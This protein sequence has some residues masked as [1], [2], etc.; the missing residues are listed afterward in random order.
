MVYSPIL[1]PPGGNNTTMDIS[2]LQEPGII[3]GTIITAGADTIFIYADDAVH[4]GFLGGTWKEMDY[5]SHVD[6]ALTVRHY[7]EYVLIA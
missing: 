7:L 5:V 2:G 3:L 4:Y 6:R 1:T